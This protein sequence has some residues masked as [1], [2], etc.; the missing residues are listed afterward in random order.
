MIKSLEPVKW[1]LR[2]LMPDVFTAVRMKLMCLNDFSTI[3]KHISVAEQ[4]HDYNVFMASEREWRRDDRVHSF[5]SLKQD[6]DESL[7]WGPPKKKVYDAY[8]HSEQTRYKVVPIVLLIWRVLTSQV[9][10]TMTATTLVTVSL[11]VAPFS[12]AWQHSA[13]SK[14][15]I[16]DA[17]FY[18]ILLNTMFQLLGLFTIMMPISQ[19]GS[20]RNWKI[21]WAF[22]IAGGICAVSAPI[23]YPYLPICWSL[24]A[25]N[26]AASAQ[27]GAVLLV[28][29]KRTWAS[30]L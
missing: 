3:V 23:L 15:T 29:L 25:S 18:G 19:T 27:A 12:L 5:Q 30:N 13:P 8:Q 4:D 20:V 6:F 17:D 16:R 2:Q 24:L 14:G 10:M 11:A 22:T 26:F 9:N 21:A 1:E 28:M 7:A